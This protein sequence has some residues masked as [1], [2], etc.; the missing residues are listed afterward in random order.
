MED[1]MFKI[2]QT[3]S[4]DYSLCFECNRMPFKYFLKE[5]SY[6]V[7]VKELILAQASPI[8]LCRL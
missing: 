4:K 7:S 6:M 1:R 8:Q 3:T 5:A 2:W